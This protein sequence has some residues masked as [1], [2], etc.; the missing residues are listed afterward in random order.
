MH[1]FLYRFWKVWEKL[2]KSLS[3]S[4]KI[5]KLWRYR[6]WNLMLLLAK[7]KKDPTFQDQYNYQWEHFC[8]SIQLYHVMRR[9]WIHPVFRPWFFGL[10]TCIK[11]F[12]PWF[13]IQSK[14]LMVDLV[15][16]SKRISGFAYTPIYP[17][18]SYFEKIAHTSV[19]WAYVSLWLC[20]FV[21]S[22]VCCKS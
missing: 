3:S 10:C 7:P 16:K 17:F 2:F 20:I 5:R 18:L 8:N 6:L 15:N 13:Q 1:T 14:I 21:C 4:W 12:L 19:V 22:D 11:F 9:F